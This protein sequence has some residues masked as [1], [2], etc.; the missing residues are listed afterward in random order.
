MWRF[1]CRRTSATIS[2]THGQPPRP[3]DDLELRE[4]HR[5]LVEMARMAEIVG[6]VVRV[7]HRRIDPYGNAELGRLRVERVVAPV[8]RGN[9]VD[10]R[11][12]P[13]RLE[14]FLAHQPLELANAGHALEGVDA[15]ARQ[16]D[17]AI[18]I[19]AQERRLLVVGDAEGHRAHDP[20]LTERGDVGVEAHVR[21]VVGALATRAEDPAV[22]RHAVARRL[23]GSR[24]LIV[25]RLGLAR[26]GLRDAALHVDDSNHHGLLRWCRTRVTG[27]WDRGRRAARPRAR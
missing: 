14:A 2:L 24:L 27:A 18:G 4:I 20:E 10:Q 3:A 19:A 1:G 5:D 9:H 11:R 12:D 22:V 7:V 26:F 16:P 15:D 13:E 17:E 21:P 6:P 8:A 23:R 25:A